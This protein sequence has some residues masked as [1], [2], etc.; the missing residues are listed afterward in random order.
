MRQEMPPRLETKM[1]HLQYPVWDD[2]NLSVSIALDCMFSPKSYGKKY[3][4]W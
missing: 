4:T 2:K 1:I 3:S